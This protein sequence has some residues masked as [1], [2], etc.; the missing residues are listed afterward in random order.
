MIEELKSGGVYM[1]SL[2][3]EAAEW[4]TRRSIEFLFSFILLISYST[5]NRT[6]TIGST[7]ETKP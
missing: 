7:T 4:E 2:Y 6:T 3:L 5:Y 1:L